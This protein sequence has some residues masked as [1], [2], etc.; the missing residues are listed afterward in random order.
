MIDKDVPPIEHFGVSKRAFILWLSRFIAVFSW[1]SN[2]DVVGVTLLTM[3]RRAYAY[4]SPS[5]DNSALKAD[6]GLEEEEEEED[7]DEFESVESADWMSVETTAKA[8][9]KGLNEL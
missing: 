9:A 3:L 2:S 1:I 5:S 4:D 7:D 8:S 6:T